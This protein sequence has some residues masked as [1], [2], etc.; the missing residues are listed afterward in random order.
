MR[1]SPIS[2]LVIENHPMMRAALCAAI[3]DEAGLVVMGEASDEIEAMRTRASHLPDVIL[4][5]L[6]T[7]PQDGMDTLV[8]IR[9]AFPQVPILA[10]TTNESRE[11]ENDA[12]AHGARV[13]LTK[14]AS[15][16]E[17]LLTLKGMKSKPEVRKKSR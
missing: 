4:L 14:A 11:Q 9:K 8:A 2:V 17:L 12:L 3:A 15:R 10:L 13:V 16:D 6:G 7:P 1:N 5:A